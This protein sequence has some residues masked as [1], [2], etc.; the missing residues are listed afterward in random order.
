MFYKKIFSIFFILLV[1]L[2]MVWITISKAASILNKDETQKTYI[3]YKKLYPLSNKGYKVSDSLISKY[4]KTTLQIKNKVNLAIETYYPFKE[5]IKYIYGKYNN[6]LNQRILYGPNTIIKM[7]NDYLT[8]WK[9]DRIETAFF[10]ESVNNFNYYLEKLQIPFAFILNPTKINKFSNSLPEGLIDYSNDNGDAFLKDL[11]EKNIKYLDLREYF[12]K[13][14]NEY[15]NLFFKTD[16]HWKPQGGLFAAQ[17]IAEY[18]TQEFPFF[19]GQVI[20]H[21]SFYTEIPDIPYLGSQG[22]RAGLGYTSPEDFYFLKTANT[23]QLTVEVPNNNKSYTGLFNTIMFDYNIL[24]NSASIYNN[25]LYTGYL[26]DGR[27]EIILKNVTIPHKSKILWLRDSSSLVLLPA[28]S[29]S[30]S[31]IRVIDLRT[32]DGSIKKLIESYKPDLVLCVYGVS[33]LELNGS[34]NKTSL[35][36]FE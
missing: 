10:S 30:F 34:T 9:P 33:Q 26:Y 27:P 16:H 3:D 14:E 13:D 21:S 22:I 23:I 25:K 7:D 8:Y 4:K 28:L 31:E 29:L 15:L 11:K 5:T 32:F 2:S 35:F 20:D 18:I 12:P 19:S 36:D 6:I 17:L 1:F 24:N